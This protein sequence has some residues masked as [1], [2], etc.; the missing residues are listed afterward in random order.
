MDSTGRR[1]HDE[2]GPFSSPASGRLRSAIGA[3]VRSGVCWRR[4]GTSSG[5]GCGFGLAAARAR[6]V[7]AAWLGRGAVRVRPRGCPRRG[8]DGEAAVE[9]V[10]AVVHLA[11]IV[12]DPACAREPEGS[13]ASTSARRASS[14]T[15]PKRPASAVRVRF[16]V[17][18]LRQARDGDAFATEDWPLRPVSLYAETKVEAEL[19]MLAPGRRRLRDL[20]PFRH[21]LRR[22]AADALRPDRERVHARRLRWTATWSSTA[23]SSGAP[24]STCATRRAAFAPC[25]MRQPSRSPARSTT[26][27]RR[28]ENYR[29]LDLVEL[30]RERIPTAEIEFVT[31][32]EDPRDYRVGFEPDRGAA[33]LRRRRARSRR[34][35][36][37]SSPCCAADCSTTRTPAPTGT[38]RKRARGPGSAPLS[39]SRS[40]PRPCGGCR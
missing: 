24:T 21:G 6:T 31:E 26:S 16:H 32:D 15:P 23:S 13:R 29:K 35:S 33:G 5:R 2:N 28:E 20:P 8:R 11:A 36:T 38:R 10:D 25:S 17:Q 4:R 22:L 27:A 30:L 34:E 40:V 19:D 7:A 39:A 9:D 18:Q 37:R 3:V 1:R 14:S 12:G